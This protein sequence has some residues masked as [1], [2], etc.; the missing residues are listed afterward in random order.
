MTLTTPFYVLTLFLR[1]AREAGKGLSVGEQG[2]PRKFLARAYRRTDARM[3]MPAE[4]ICNPARPLLFSRHYFPFQISLSHRNVPGLAC[5]F[6]SFLCL[7]PAV[8][9]CMQRPSSDVTTA[10]RLP[11]AFSLGLLHP[12]TP[13]L[14][15]WFVLS[16]PG[17]AR[18]G[19]ALCRPPCESA[20]LL[21]PP[22]TQCVGFHDSHLL[23]S[24][25]LPPSLTVPTSSVRS[26]PNSAPSKKP[27]QLPGHSTDFSFR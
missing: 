20:G 12:M 2:A 16:C 14:L 27:A 8:N 24:G 1:D 26:V 23:E 6:W 10:P 11:H 9:T 25:L 22:T 17:H 19:H 5:G 21:C 7:L 4:S 15:L 18:W 3:H 13:S